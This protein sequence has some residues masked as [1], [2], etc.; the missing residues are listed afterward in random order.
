[1]LR[2]LPATARCTNLVHLERMKFNNFSLILIETHS[3]FSHFL[4]PIGYINSCL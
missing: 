4:N 2:P 3:P 1:M